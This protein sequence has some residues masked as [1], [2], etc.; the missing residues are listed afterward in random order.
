MS[1]GERGEMI[2]DEFLHRCGLLAADSFDQVVVAR[3]D[4]VLVVN[5]TPVSL[6]EF[7]PANRAVL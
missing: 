5:R 6:R 7:V 3:E 1:A 4:S 2:G